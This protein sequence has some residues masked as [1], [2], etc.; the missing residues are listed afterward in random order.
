MKSKWGLLFVFGVLAVLCGCSSGGGGKGANNGS[1]SAISL[2]LTG[3][4]AEVGMLEEGILTLKV[5]F[6]FEGDVVGVGYAP[7]Q[8]NSN[9]WVTYAEPVIT[10]SSAGYVEVYVNK[11]ELREP[12]TYESQLRFAAG[13]TGSTSS[14]VY[15]DIPVRVVVKNAIQIVILYPRADKRWS[16]IG[17]TGFDP[18]ITSGTVYTGSEWNIATDIEW[19]R[20]DRGL[21]EGSF[22]LS[23]DEETKPP[24]GLHTIAVTATSIE[25]PSLSHTFE[26]ELEILAPELYF[27][28]NKEQYDLTIGDV[29]MGGIA[30]VSIFGGS[31]PEEG[32]VV[33]PVEALSDTPWLVVEDVV[34]GEYGMQVQFSIDANKAPQVGQFEAQLTLI[35]KIPGGEQSRAFNIQANMEPSYIGIQRN[36]VAL[37]VTEG[38]TVLSARRPIAGYVDTL[39]NLT[40]PTV[41]SSENWLSASISGGDLMLVAD[42]AGMADGFYTAQVSLTSNDLRLIGNDSVTVGLY[43]D[44]TA[45]SEDGIL[46]RYSFIYQFPLIVSDPIRPIV[47]VASIEDHR[48]TSW[49]IHTGQ[50]REIRLFNPDDEIIGMTVSADGS[51]LYVYSTGTAGIQ[52]YNL[53]TSAWES[54]LNVGYGASG[55]SFLRAEGENILAFGNCF[56]APETGAPLNTLPEFGTCG[57]SRIP[58]ALDQP[59]IYLGEL[60]RLGFDQESQSVVERKRKFYLLEHLADD[61]ALSPDAQ[62]IAWTSYQLEDSWRVLFLDEERGSVVGRGTG[63]DRSVDLAFDPAGKIY[64]A[65]HNGW[66]TRVSVFRVD[67]TVESEFDVQGGLLPDRLIFSSDE[68]KMIML[69]ADEENGDFYLRAM[70]K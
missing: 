70:N 34:V 48:I 8:G 21:A 62:Y 3:L 61:L 56:F 55:L 7:G 41:T 66:D 5:P 45:S 23:L 57:G 25:D 19:V 40:P 6:T 53:S 50:E 33:F 59:Y 13:V 38:H 15:K 49:N 17:L 30:T 65:V 18:Y 10:S 4:N 46:G 39:E 16:Q 20:A 43:I 11:S 68:S 22:V 47:Y 63:L 26:V 28:I 32:R 69:M 12:G 36:G 42:A 54:P 67:G 29:V 64:R 27:E 52:K 60:V 24:V 58:V 2:S 1:R 51:H 37:T 31:S 35:A 14:T 44:R 9:S